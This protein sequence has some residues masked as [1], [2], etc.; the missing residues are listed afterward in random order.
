MDLHRKLLA[1]HLALIAAEQQTYEHIHGHIGSTEL[2]LQLM[3]KDPWFTWLH[4]L[5]DILVKIDHLLNNETF[6]ATEE[7]VDHLF[8]QICLLLQPSVEGEGF[9]RAYYE[10][11]QG[12]PDVALAH[13]H[14]RQVLLAEAA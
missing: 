1:L 11:L 4:P 7:N 12:A 9:E 6:D 14:V 10:A 13:F 2:L 8:H 3:L 5:S